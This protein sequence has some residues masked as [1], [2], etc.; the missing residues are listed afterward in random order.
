MNIFNRALLE[1]LILTLISLLVESVR[2]SLEILMSVKSK[3]TCLNIK[4]SLRLER[5][6]SP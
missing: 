2:L 1:S 4:P 3:Y 6:G 5:K